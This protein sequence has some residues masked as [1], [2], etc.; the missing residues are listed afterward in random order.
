MKKPGR[1]N[2][3]IAEQVQREDRVTPVAFV[4]LALI[5]AALYVQVT[6]KQKSQQKQEIALNARRA[7]LDEKIAAMTRIQ[8]NAK[9]FESEKKLIFDILTKR[10]PWSNSLKDLT[11]R[12]PRDIWLEQLELSSAEGRKS[13]EI[14][15]TAKT[16]ASVSDFFHSLEGSYFFRRIMIDSSELI[17]NVAPNVY[18]FKFHCPLDD[19]QVKS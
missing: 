9:N 8:D 13:V 6:W 18:K 5:I 12:V 1:I 10:T 4:A 16:A 19:L 3:I 11:M 2:L 7:E 14:Y 17:E 15:G